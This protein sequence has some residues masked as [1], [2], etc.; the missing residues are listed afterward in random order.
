[1]PLKKGCSR[2]VVSQNI[3]KLRHEGYSQPQ[4]VAA[5][6]SNARRTG[7]GAC[8]PGPNPNRQRGRQGGPR[9]AITYEIVTPESAEIGDAEERGWIDEE[10]VLIEPD[11][12]NDETLVE[13]AA[14]FLRDEGATEP[15]SSSFHRGVWY[16]W[17]D[18]QTDYRTG[19]ETTQSY[20]LRGFTPAQEEQIHALVTR[21]RRR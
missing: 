8:R 14:K 9:I 20:H 6:L 11:E 3:R 12:D 21:R 10:G 7:R 4:A 5:A 13:A 15:S 2:T 16:S 19:A 17:P 1:M 18:S